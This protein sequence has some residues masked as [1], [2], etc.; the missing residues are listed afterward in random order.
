MKQ[1]DQ[2]SRTTSPT[3][4]LHSG[5]RDC[6]G[7]PLGAS[8][9]TLSTSSPL[10]SD[11]Y[12]HS[13]HGSYHHNPSLVTRSPMAT[14]ATFVPVPVRSASWAAGTQEARSPSNS[15]PTIITTQEGLSDSSSAPSMPNFKLQQKSCSKPLSAVK[16]KH[17]TKGDKASNGGKNGETVTARR[18]KRLERN[19]ES[20]R[21]SRR[22]RKQYLEV[23]EDRVTQ[24]SLEM[25]QGRRAHAAAAIE[26]VLAKRRE[27][28]DESRPVDP[29]HALPALDTS[30]SRTSQELSVLNTF[31]MQQL[32]SF[33][34]P[35]HSK[36]VLWLTLQG[37]TYFRGG[38]AASERLS[39]AR[40]GERMLQSGNDRVTPVNSMWPLFCNE[41]GLSYDQEERVRMYQ[42]TLLQ[43]SPTWLERHTARASSLVM[44]SFHDS[45]NAVGSRLHQR[46]RTSTAGLS[47][48]QRMQFLSWAEKNAERLRQKFHAKRQ[49]LG[50]E[51]ESDEFKILPSQ[52]TAANLYILNDRLQKIIAQ[53]SPQVEL[54]NAAY[55]K[56]LSRR[57][58]FESLGQQKDEDGEFMTRE[59]SFASSGSLKRSVSSLSMVSENGEEK[60]P[61][62]V[63]PE[64]G[65]GTAV[66]LIEQELGFVKKL[67]PPIVQPVLPPAPAPAPVSLPPAPQAYNPHHYAPAPAPH[68]SYQEMP[69]SHPYTLAPH[70]H[71]QQLVTPQTQHMHHQG[72]AY[73]AAPMPLQPT[74]APAPA[75]HHTY[76]QYYAAPAPVAHPQPIYAQ[77]V[78]APLSSQPPMVYSAPPPPSSSAPAPLAPE[79]SQH[80]RKNSFLPP[81]LNVVPEE[82]FPAADGSDDFL[83]SLIDDGDWA[84]GEGVDMDTAS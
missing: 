80:V 69:P 10:S 38:R 70:H 82:M 50:K 5:Y 48:E 75:D 60:A 51:K 28:L 32:K 61:Q 22:R 54:V 42:R 27:L 45:A 78:P 83:M 4:L 64:D 12:N 79:L 18:Q 63:S 68:T 33:A 52:H 43:D 3:V 31:Q 76:Q 62:Q 11:H 46:E 24:L 65:E 66:P 77:P 56:R 19:R 41:V 14:S 20:A 2:S 71:H 58:S 1:E 16:K 47:P 35:P 8:Q 55:L 30:L 72:P 44:Q 57:P 26:T 15:V 23:L 74:S 17:N 9:S 53:F 21:L 84:I 34:L 67:I 7:S 40:I 59:N 36:F 49:A 81:H 25:D 13:L 37:D 39:A 6:A 29:N 73:T